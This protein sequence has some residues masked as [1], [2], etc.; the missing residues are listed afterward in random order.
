MRR[1]CEAYFCDSETDAAVCLG[2]CVS[3]I[4]RGNNTRAMG[5]LTPVIATTF[6]ESVILQ[7]WFGP[8]WV[9][10]Y[11]VAP[12]VEASPFVA[13]V[14]LTVIVRKKGNMRETVTEKENLNG[15]RSKKELFELAGEF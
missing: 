11:G 5:L 13:L 8:G 2:I 7:S 4:Y 15:L 3:V 12:F 6:S 10:R 9:L 1:V 14:P